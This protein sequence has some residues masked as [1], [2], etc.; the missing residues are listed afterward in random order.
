MKFLKF[1]RKYLDIG[2]KY[3]VFAFFLVT[4]MTITIA[5]VQSDSSGEAAI[6]DFETE[7]FN[8]GW[9]I[10]VDGG[11]EVVVTLPDKL[12]CHKG[13]IIS[14]QNT[15][16]E[17]V[18]DGMN[19]MMRSDMQDVLI[20]IDGELRNSYTS[21]E[22][23]LKRFHIASAYVVTE[24]FSE[25]AGKDIRFELTVTNSGSLSK[26]TLGFGNNGWF[27]IVKDNIILFFAALF[28]VISGIIVLVF[29]GMFREKLHIGKSILYLGMLTVMLGNWIISESKLRQLVFQRPSLTNLFAYYSFEII[30]LL[31]VLYFDEVQKG[32]YHRIYQIL[33][34]LISIQLL[35]CCILDFVHVAEFHQTLIVSHILMVVSIVVVIVN[36]VKDIISRAAMHYRFVA[37]GMGVF[38]FCCLV[39]LI[40]F[41]TSK[42]LTFGPFLC[43]GFI[44]LVMTT[45]V[46]VIIDEGD[47]IHT[48]ENAHR[49]SWINTVET[50]SS[51]IES[52][53]EYTGGHSNRVGEYASIL[54]REMAADYDFSEDDI[55]RVRYIGLMHDIGKIGV[56]DT[57]LNKAGK[58][59]D[60][61][62]TL[63][64][65]HA[66][67]GYDLLG[68]MGNNL[69]GLLDGVRHHHERFDGHGYPDGLEGTDIPLIARILCLADCYDAMTSNRV[70]RR[71]LSDEE[72]RAEIVKCAGTQFDPALAD[73]FVRIIDRGDLKPSTVDGMEVNAEGE[74]F[75]SSLLE[76][77]L[78]KDMRKDQKERISNPSHIRMLCYIIKLAENKGRHFEMMLAK[79]KVESTTEDPNSLLNQA[80]RPHILN[81]DICIEYTET[82]NI[83]VLF[84]RTKEEIETFKA[85]LPEEI[86]IEDFK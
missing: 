28:C 46:Q 73:I 71:R 18:S 41:Y 76:E 7:E 19:V 85:N 2:I 15:L 12:D 23:L 20:Y 1:D 14:M 33:E 79:L 65:K 36:I 32:R 55:L 77:K 31:A 29:Y 5:F 56:A 44:A 34:A 8:T 74:L 81:K 54:A 58:L 3:F 86:V 43:M 70:Y 80:L 68:G 38:I 11:E 52:K 61:E 63:M 69:E 48:R 64:K 49:D 66:E 37:G 4:V 60:E 22:L 67:I 24:L 17:D 21:D 9:T 50:I 26:V 78:Q 84:D 83:V 13:S 16:P 10:R 35:I 72:V 53:D 30:P 59:T 40:V 42:V 25:D 62:F 51:A 82:Q 6:G 45:V 57:I 47:R 39:E 75:K 27:E